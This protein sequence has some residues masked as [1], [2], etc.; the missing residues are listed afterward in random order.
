MASSVITGG[1]TETF[2]QEA[3]GVYENRR[4]ILR[5]GGGLTSSVDS[6]HPACT[7]PWIPSPWL[8]KLGMMVHACTGTWEEEEEA[9]RSEIQGHL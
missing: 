6:A 1:T 8:H 9:V 2:L 3:L 4:C 7:K 5:A